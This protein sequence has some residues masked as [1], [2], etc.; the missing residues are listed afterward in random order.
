MSQEYVAWL[1]LATIANDM[2]QTAA[3]SASMNRPR[4]TTPHLV[5]LSISHE[6]RQRSSG[7]RSTRQHRAL[8]PNARKVAAKV[9][10]GFHSQKN[11]VFFRICGL[12]KEASKRHHNQIQRDIHIQFNANITENRKL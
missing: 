7:E 1:R 11:A 2:T 10:M 5:M 4:H 12:K 6:L 3:L 8:F 9:I